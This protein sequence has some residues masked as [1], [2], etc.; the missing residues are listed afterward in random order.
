MRRIFSHQHNVLITA[1]S[2]CGAFLTLLPETELLIEANGDFIIMED[3][4]V[5]FSYG[6]P[7]EGI[8]EAK[9]H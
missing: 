1:V 7:V 3:F 9:F 8:G 2:E 6:Q 4:Q 5:D